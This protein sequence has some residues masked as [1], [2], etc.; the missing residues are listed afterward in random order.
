MNTEFTLNTVVSVR[1]SLVHFMHKN[2]YWG[3]YGQETCKAVVDMLT[4]NKRKMF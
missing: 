4:F 1:A 2:E 3:L